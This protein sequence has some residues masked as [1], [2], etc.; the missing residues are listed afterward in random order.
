M[1]TARAA[2]VI[3]QDI[4][5]S[6]SVCPKPTARREHNAV[7]SCERPEAG[8]AQA[9][10]GGRGSGVAAAGLHRRRAWCWRWV[11]WADWRSSWASWARSGG[12]RRAWQWCGCSRAA[13]DRAA[14]AQGPVLVVGGRA[15]LI[16]GSH[17]AFIAFIAS[18]NSI[19]TTHHC[20]QPAPPILRRGCCG[21]C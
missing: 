17:C 1:Q 16:A 14:S 8:H 2:G 19:S 18:H 10:R 12:T 9:A 6:V 13:S 20:T 4:S 15:V 11:G 21:W 3:G 7:G 5:L